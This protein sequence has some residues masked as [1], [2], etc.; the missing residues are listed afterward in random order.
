[1]KVKN[2][3]L[4]VLFFLSQKPRPVSFKPAARLQYAKFSKVVSDN[5]D[6]LGK[7]EVE[8]AKNIDPDFEKNGMQFMGKRLAE[9]V[10]KFNDEV[11]TIRDEEIELPD[12]PSFKLSEWPEL[13]LTDM[14]LMELLE[15]GIV[16]EE[17]AKK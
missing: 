14:Q 4:S 16:E 1:M 8:V 9:N 5:I 12:I 7:V 15:I 6:T 10:F 3:N 2:K 13:S 17:E 11:K